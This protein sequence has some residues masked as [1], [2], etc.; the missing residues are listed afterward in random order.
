MYRKAYIRAT[1]AD[2]KYGK[3][4]TDHPNSNRLSGC[5]S[6]SNYRHSHPRYRVPS[7]N[8]VSLFTAVL[9]RRRVSYPPRILGRLPQAFVIRSLPPVNRYDVHRL[10][11]FPRVARF[12]QCFNFQCIPRAWSCSCTHPSWV[13]QWIEDTSARSALCSGRP[14]AHRIETRRT[15]P[16]PRT[17]LHVIGYQLKQRRIG[18]QRSSGLDSRSLP[19]LRKATEYEPTEVGGAAISDRQQS[20][21]VRCCSLIPRQ[22]A[23]AGVNDSELAAAAS[24]RECGS[25]RSATA[26]SCTVFVGR[27]ANATWLD[28]VKSGRR[29]RRVESDVERFP[30]WTGSCSGAADRPSSPVRR[31]RPF[32][33]HYLA[34]LPSTA[35]S[36]PVRSVRDA[37]FRR[38]AVRC[39]STLRVVV[40]RSSFGA[41]CDATWPNMKTLER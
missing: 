21:E 13:R 23:D 4:N 7:R 22:M 34:I 25:Q 30:D 17:A 28:C 19:T 1:S 5:S 29:V 2:F 33:L 26:A 14:L 32:L 35:S 6:T 15:Q 18:S 24:T 12:K 11:P 40:D 10:I 20:E 38:E 36:V 3:F 27:H 39:S 31:R 37:V 41:C 16:Q 8:H 9:M